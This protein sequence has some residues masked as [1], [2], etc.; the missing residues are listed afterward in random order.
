MTT[1]KSKDSSPSINTLI[2]RVELIEI[3]QR[4]SF[5]KSF[6]EILQN[7]TER[8]ETLEEKLDNPETLF[9]LKD[10]LK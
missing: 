6:K 3:F 7:L 4:D 2:K 5:W 10:I 8:V 9:D 1:I